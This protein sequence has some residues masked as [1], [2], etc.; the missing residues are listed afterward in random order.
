MAAGVGAYA[1]VTRAAW[2]LDDRLTFRDPRWLTGGVRDLLDLGG[3]NAPT[4][5]RPVTA[6]TLLL[7][8][9]AA[10][11]ERPGEPPPPELRHAVSL[12][13]HLATGLLL[14]ALL[15]RTL[16]RLP[17]FRPA[18]TGLAFASAL[19]WLVH[20]L[21]TG[22][23]VYVSQRSEVL[24]SFFILL[25]LLLAERAASGSHARAW[26]AAAVASCWLAVGSKE[27]AA[28]T[29]LL[30]LLHDRAFLAGSFRAAWR[31]R[32]GL[33]LGLLSSWIG[34]AA[35]LATD[36]RPDSVAWQQHGITPLNYL[37]TQAGALFTYL[38]LCLWPHPLLLDYGWPL[39]P[40]A[41]ARD[42]LTQLPRYGPSLAGA[43]ALVGLTGWAVVR[44]P[45]LGFLLAWPLILLAPSSSLVPINTEILAEHRMYLPLA[46]LT[47]GSVVAAWRLGGWLSRRLGLSRAGVWGLG[48]CALAACA[49]VL[50]G[51]T[52][53][54][55]ALYGSEIAVW[56]QNLEET[57]D[58]PRV[59]INLGTALDRAGR[60]S[61]A[62]LRLEQAVEASRQIRIPEKPYLGWAL[63]KVG[64][65]Y[66][67]LGDSPRAIAF[68]QEAIQVDPGVADAYL[69][70][71][72][73]LAGQGRLQEALQVQRAAL[74]ID[75]AFG[76]ARWNAAA[77]LLRLGRLAE[78]RVEM[79]RVLDEPPGAPAVTDVLRELAERSGR[80]D[81]ALQLL[82]DSGRPAAG[83][84]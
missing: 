28:V 60:R 15:A 4:A 51:L 19:L 68:L 6:L 10:P 53:A 54:R 30:V 31:R 43:L 49:L 50:G 46:A 63:A 66:H 65:L 52:R 18:A 83:S 75:P 37:L 74:A 29:P 22:A 2:I 26:S 64:E 13:L 7:D 16:G 27:V 20:P 79:G 80:P 21:Q 77:L 12:G 58:N 44:R 33:Y 11:P 72:S 81:L 25:T 70:L 8:L 32:R 24:V 84:R 48:A 55:T 38:R 23:V 67:R 78:A 45:R 42:L 71:G 73:E 59:L 56:E 35:L 61:E 47:T 9:R 62:L 76:K 39:V 17:P 3:K 57:P 41:S 34:L 5:G 69:A 14:F 82:R 40:V 36:P 1:A